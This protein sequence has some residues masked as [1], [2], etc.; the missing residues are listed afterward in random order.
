ML[1]HT[2]EDIIS[3]VREH[4]VRIKVAA[5]MGRDVKNESVSIGSDYMMTNPADPQP[6]AIKDPVI[7]PEPARDYIFQWIASLL[8]VVHLFLR[9]C[10]QNAVWELQLFYRFIW[11]DI[12]AGVLGGCAYT[13]PAAKFC[14]CSLMDFVTVIPWALLYFFLYQYS[15]NLSN[16]IAGVEEDKINKPDRP[17][18]SGL[19][20]LQG[21][22]HRWY[23]VAALYIIAGMAIGNVWSSLLWIIA[24]S[25][26]NDCG[27]DKH[28]F[29]KNSII[30]VIGV[31]VQAW[32]SWSIVYGSLWMSRD[33]TFFLGAILFYVGTTL[34]IQDLRDADG[35]Y[36]CG[37]K[38]M[39]LQFGVTW[40]RVFVSISFIISVVVLYFAVWD[41][42]MQEVTLFKVI[43]MFIEVV[44]H[45][46]IILHTLFLDQKYSEFHHTY[47]FYTKSY[48]FTVMNVIAFL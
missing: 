19:I 2:L 17:I 10:L 14:E 12:P 44:V 24:M 22:K 30:M 20:T 29:T 47:H 27:W 28:W 26:H 41:Q 7:Q 23:V 38:T 8:T 37:R 4:T 42:Y 39:P 18:P 11:R 46:Y 33:Y 43:Y 36:Q 3:A 25:L 5:T 16:Q 40:T 45:L 35:D 32:A 31:I 1:S 15:F 34:N 48:V 21:A 9:Q 13:V 6:Q